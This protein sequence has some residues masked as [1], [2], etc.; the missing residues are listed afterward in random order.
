MIL[1]KLS[2]KYLDFKKRSIQIG[3]A[4]LVL[5]F[6]V[7]GMIIFGGGNS[8]S[9]FSPTKTEVI[10]TTI[11]SASPNIDQPCSLLSSAEASALLGATVEDGENADI[12]D[13]TLRCRF[14]ATTPDGNYF[15][16]VNVYVFKTKKSYDALYVA[17]NGIK[18]DTNVDDGFYAV[19][20]KTLE[21]ERIVAVIS[22][23]KRVAVSASMAAIQ[24]NQTLTEEQLLIPDANTLAQ[25]AG[26]IM[27]KLK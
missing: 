24:S 17:N 21:T 11:P 2:V 14:D 5:F 15:L 25:Y 16:N 6:I 26:D 9:D 7:L 19:R 10:K 22:A 1:N 3:S 27:A 12:D 20:Q 23:D 13:D 18:I 4:V 8:D